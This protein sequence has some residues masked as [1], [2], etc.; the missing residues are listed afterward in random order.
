[1]KKRP[2]TTLFVATIVALFGCWLIKSGLTR[3]ESATAKSASATAAYRNDKLP[4]ADR[5]HDLLGRMTQAEKVAQLQSVNWD[6]THVYDRR[7]GEFSTERARKLMPLG[8]GHVTR[9]GDRHDPRQAVEFAN[10]LQKFMVE[11]TRLG[12]PAILHEEGLHGFVA[13]GATSFPQAIAL[14]ATFDPQL[15]E[16][17]F[18]VAARQMRARGGSQVLAPV[19]D[20][21]RD[22]R[23]G[24]IEETYG[25]DPYLAGRI[26]V[27]AVLGFQGRRA[28][29]DVAISPEHVVATTKHLTGHGQPEGGR[30]TAPAAIG[31]RTLREI[32]LPPFEAALS[33]GRAESVMA[34]YNEID[35]VPSHTN[36]WML[37][38][39]L[40]GEWGFRGVVVSDYSGVAE[41]ARKHHVVEDLVSAGRSA[42]A[43]GVDVELPEPEGFASLLADL[44]AGRIAE[45]D[46]DQAVA[47]VLR[48][49]LLLGLFEHPYGPNVAPESER[50]TD[51]ALAR[52]AAQE[53]IVLLKND[54]GLLPLDPAR[55][56]SLAVI[57]PNAE[58]CRLGGY[59]GV[60]DKTVSVVEGL[61]AR[62][63]DKVKLLTAKGC[64]LTEGNRG[65]NDSEVTLSDPASDR[66]L[67]A[68]AGKLAAQADAVLLVIGQNEQLSREAWS[69]THL[70]DRSSLDLVG[71]QMDLARA[72][73][74]SGRPTVVLLI[75]GGPLSIS[76]LARTAP[77]ILDGFY[78]GEETGNA[79][80]D[81]LFGDVSPAAR[82]PVSI[83]RSVATVPAFYNRKPSADRLHLFEEA[84]P[85]WPF[86][87]G[88]SYTTFRYDRL[89]VTPARIAPDGKARVSVTVTNTGKRAAD[90]VVQLYLHDVVAS[91]ARPIK[92][93]KGFRRVHLRPGQS[94]IV[95]FDVGT[96]ELGLWDKQMKF[97]VEPG[98]FEVMVGASSAD[99]RQQGK[100]G[101]AAAR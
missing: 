80:A 30:N 73:L 92:E 42:L 78:L 66:S 100:L 2:M 16:E 47:R 53:A 45:A 3:A 93:L 87:H 34:S 11:E 96:Q 74:A 88:L 14:A 60:P 68:E 9:P 67:V 59:S 25:E 51:R 20:V 40:R 76:E 83:P 69:S 101:V 85:L 94:E 65:W 49:K 23:W 62:L 26:G 90:E 86:G 97:V 33:E 35:G 52:R 44:K 13:P 89:A 28:S 70:G 39:L 99:I 46:V 58:V 37:T 56:K 41:L 77:A 10:A 95:A 63:G 6:N 12:I 64:G 31:P 29:N 75:H 1:M 91:V 48:V 15:V 32:F 5:V 7:T 98:V 54:R 71:A 43:A 36:R 50:V 84:G 8:I 82:L 4:V 27:A 55:L 79:V 18:T 17:A 57:G 24:R 72:V 38:D 22:P 61:R 21:A 19:L 81:V